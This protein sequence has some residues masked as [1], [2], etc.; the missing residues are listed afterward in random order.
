MPKSLIY[1]AVPVFLAT[2]IAWIIGVSNHTFLAKEFW[3]YVGIFLIPGLL[4]C[5][6]SWLIFHSQLWRRI[7]GLIILVPCLAIWVLS[8]LLVSNGFKIH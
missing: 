4:V 6:C 7:L 3:L 1:S 8:L 2:T 5:G